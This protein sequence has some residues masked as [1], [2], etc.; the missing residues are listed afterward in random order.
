MPSVGQVGRLDRSGYVHE[1]PDGP[2]RDPSEAYPKEF[3][4]DWFRASRRD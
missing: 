4:V 2:D 1:F 3:V